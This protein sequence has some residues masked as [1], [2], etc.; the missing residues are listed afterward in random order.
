MQYRSRVDIVRDMLTYVNDDT[1]A[2]G[3]KTKTHIMY[4]TYLSYSQLKDYLEYLM[5]NKFVNLHNGLYSISPSGL[6]M[7]TKLEELREI[8]L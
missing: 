4:A 2:K 3:Q 8:G 7:L 1:I 6:A 5:K